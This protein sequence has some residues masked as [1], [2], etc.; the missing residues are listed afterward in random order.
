MESHKASL[1]NRTWEQC[2]RASGGWG[3][4]REYRDTA[5]PSLS[6]VLKLFG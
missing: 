3:R 2:P 5:E 4:A 6:L 1:A